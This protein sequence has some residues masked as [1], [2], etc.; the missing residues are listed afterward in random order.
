MY[1]WGRS[2]DKRAPERRANQNQD[3]YRQHMLMARG[4]LAAGETTGARNWLERATAVC[5]L[6]A[7][8]WYLLAHTTED[9]SRKRGYLERALSLAPNH[10][11]ARR[12]MA[13]LSGELERD[14]ILPEGHTVQARTPEEVTVA[15]AQNFLCAA[16]GGAFRF[17]PSNQ[18]LCCERC[19]G[20]KR[21]ERHCG[22]E[23]EQRLELTLPTRQAHQWAEAHHAVL[24]GQCGAETML[25][26]AALSDACPYCGS[27]AVI[28]SEEIHGE[29]PNPQA[30]APVRVS[31]NDASMLARLWLDN[32][33]GKGF[34]V[35]RMRAAY[36]PLWTFDAHYELRLRQAR[37]EDDPPRP[38]GLHFDDIPVAG[39]TRLDD[40]IWPV[41]PPFQLKEVVLFRPEFL[42]GWPALLMDRTLAD[43]S[44]LA[45]RTMVDLA[46]RQGSGRWATD[47]IG[48]F[49]DLTYKLL[50]VPLWIGH[51][52]TADG[53]FPIVVNGQT[54][55]VGGGAPD[56]EQSRT[57]AG[58]RGG[59]G[60]LGWLVDRLSAESE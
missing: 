25:P 60:L 53:A 5:P 11:L 3:T 28:G 33:Y 6:E 34:P 37:D 19:G 42:A 12:E 45:R 14:A 57:G 48:T 7:E 51:Y 35:P 59:S 44:L 22:A 54:R 52:R 30:I 31:Q 50:L 32:R 27:D 26:P 49:S 10:V 9:Q 36:Y 17:D 21:V 47:A 39:C 29:L 8:P 43:A 18:R 38:R 4:S 20:E 2:S 1:Q 23:A 13:I 40:E 16:C 56:R 46:R 58:T 55:Q 24:C 15:E 41:L